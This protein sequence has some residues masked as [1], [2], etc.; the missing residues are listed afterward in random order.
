MGSNSCL[1]LHSPNGIEVYMTI[2]GFARLGL[3]CN[4]SRALE[5]IARGQGP[6]AALLN[7]VSGSHLRL[8]TAQSE[9]AAKLQILREAAHSFSA[10]RAARVS[11]QRELRKRARDARMN[12]SADLRKRRTLLMSFMLD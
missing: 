10:A 12:D 4:E 9:C 2:P 8:D 6:V 7:L 3:S 11:W 1:C 5:A